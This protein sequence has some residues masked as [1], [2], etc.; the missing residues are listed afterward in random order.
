MPTNPVISPPPRARRDGAAAQGSTNGHA[1]PADPPA[2]SDWPG[3][4]V[5]LD[6]FRRDLEP[7]CERVAAWAAERPDRVK[8]VYADA[9][10]MTVTLYLVRRQNQYDSDL[11]KQW[12]KFDRELVRDFKAIN[13][14]ARQVA[15]PAVNTFI[16]LR[17]ARRIYGD[18]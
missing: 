5:D 13:V 2:A 7:M 6:R 16:N 14:E 12:V 15:E 3:L 1:P 9:G 8:A 18:A 10:L 17:Q 4:D 11:L